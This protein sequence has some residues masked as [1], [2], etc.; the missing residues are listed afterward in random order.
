MFWLLREG[1]INATR[2][3][4]R[5]W[6][7]LYFSLQ[8]ILPAGIESGVTAVG[9]AARMVAGLEAFFGVVAVALFASYVFR[10]SLHR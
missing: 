8:N 4:I 6:D 3:D 2:S 1:L 9:I 10:W 7:A 5:P